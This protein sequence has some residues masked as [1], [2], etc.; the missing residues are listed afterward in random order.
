[1][2]PDWKYITEDEPR[3]EDDMWYLVKNGNN[4]IA[5]VNDIVFAFRKEEGNLWEG[6]V[7]TP[8]QSYCPISDITHWAEIEE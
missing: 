8:E 5:A 1:M 7:I 2:K 3:C 4:F 6:W